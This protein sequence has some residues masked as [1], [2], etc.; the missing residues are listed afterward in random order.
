MNRAILSLSLVLF[1]SSL[2]PA[3]VDLGDFAGYTPYDSYI[4]PVRQVLG[5]LEGAT[6]SLDRVKALMGEGRSFRYSHT[7]PYTAALPAVTA[8]RRIG[9]CKDKALWLCDQLGD[10]HVRFVIGKMKRSTHVR[11]AWVMWNDGRQWWILD[12]TLNY[13]PIP[14][15]RVPPGDYVPLYSWTKD[16]SYR[17]RT[18][19]PMLTADSSR[20]SA[21]VASK[22]ALR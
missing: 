7:D 13:Q 16:G 1:T 9:D 19:P 11:H 22:G 15:D 3:S 20:L 5:T 12:C 18:S 21:A 2:A 6:P 10:K 17:H 8:S 4:D 14:A